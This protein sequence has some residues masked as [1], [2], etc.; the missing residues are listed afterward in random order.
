M[1]EIS[2]EYKVKH[3]LACE[4]KFRY[5]FENSKEYSFAYH[6]YI[7]LSDASIFNDPVA[8]SK[9]ATGFYNLYDLFAD[10]IIY[11]MVKQNIN[12]LKRKDRNAYVNN[13]HINLYKNFY[14]SIF[15][16]FNALKIENTNTNIL[17]QDI[18]AFKSD[19]IT[20]IIFVPEIYTEDKK[21]TYS[22]Y[23]LQGHR[24]NYVYI[25]NDMLMKKY[26]SSTLNIYDNLYAK[27]YNTGKTNIIKNCTGLKPEIILNMYKDE[28]I[29]KDSF[30][31]NI[32]DI[33]FGRTYDN[34]L[35][36]Y[37]NPICS[38]PINILNANIN[39]L[40][41]PKDR[42][43]LNII[44]T[45]NLY[46][47]D[48]ILNII[49]QIHAKRNCYGFNIYKQISGNKIEYIDNPFHVYINEQIYAHVNRYKYLYTEHILSGTKDTKYTYRP[50]DV[51]TCKY[52]KTSSMLYYDI[53][54][55][56]DSKQSFISQK[57]NVIKNE[58]P[59]YEFDV[60][61]FSIIERKYSFT[62]NN[63]FSISNAKDTMNT[64]GI[65][66]IDSNRNIFKSHTKW[67]NI[68]EKYT[69]ISNP[70]T[71]VFKKEIDS[72][73]TGK[74]FIHKKEK[75]IFH[76]N[77]IFINI[78]SKPMSILNNLPFYKIPK[79]MC[80]DTNSFIYKKHKDIADKDYSVFINTIPDDIWIHQNI[81]IFNKQKPLDLIYGNEH[82]YKKQYNLDVHNDDLFIDRKDKD[83]FCLNNVYVYK[84]PKDFIISDISTFI[85]KVQYD[86][87]NIQQNT[88]AL[89]K[90]YD[91]G[92]YNKYVSYDKDKK[93]I[94]IYKQAHSIL[95]ERIS[96]DV[97]EINNLI[98][99][100]ISTEFIY[101]IPNEFDYVI[102]PM[103]KVKH[104]IY[105]DSI[106]NMVY[107]ISHSCG[108]YISQDLFGSII[109]KNVHIDT[110]IFCDKSNHKAFIEYK[111]NII[112][113]S[114]VYNLIHNDIFVT[115]EYMHGFIKDYFYS[116]R[117][118]DKEAWIK[119][120]ESINKSYHESLI[121]DDI[122]G[123]MSLKYCE[124][125]DSLFID[126]DNK[127]CYYDYGIFTNKENYE[128][129]ILQQ[130]D[131]ATN[132]QRDINLL[133]LSYVDRITKY[134]I[135][136]EQSIFSSKIIRDS[137]LYKEIESIYRLSYDLT[138]RPED[139]GNW[140][141]VYET[142]DPLEEQYGIDELLIPENDT[143]YEDFENIIFDKEKMK[144]R[145]PVKV[146]DNTTFIAKYPHK[147]PIPEY[148][149]IAINYDDSAVKYENYYGIEVSIMRTV[150]LKYYRIWQSKI[151][152]FGTMTMVQAV[153]KMLE[154]LYSWI[155]IYFPPSQIEQALRVFKLIRW[156]AESAIIQN[157]QYIVS[158]EYDT[159]ESKLT[160]GT[161]AIP[162]NL[163]PLTN[164]TM[165]IDSSLGVIKNNPIYI[166]TNNDV[167]VEFY[168]DNHKNTSITFSLSN[169]VGS[170]NIYIN[171]VL[172]DIISKSALNLTYQIP[173]T[174][175]TNIVKIEK[176]AS[177]NLNKYFYIGNIKVPELTFKDLS[178]EFDATVKMGN[179]PLNEIAKKM[180]QFA[181]MYDDFNEA[182]YN[183][184]RNNL[185][186]QETYNKMIEYWNLHHQNKT[187]G[188]R[189]TIKE[190]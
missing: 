101:K 182:Y 18:L 128:L 160:S 92:L 158:Y 10:K 120:V 53:S 24:N 114:K 56:N 63:V 84:I 135:F 76:L 137:E 8:I 19:P 95:K 108:G 143:R 121:H 111:N 162:N 66:G 144:P 117:K 184:R 59:L 159:L 124:I 181:N 99:D 186:I 116:I 49:S 86:L 131:F 142:P 65:W 46:I 89:R 166:G 67:I 60:D 106:D 119:D 152:E 112:T 79:D 187:K 173:Y 83:I 104:Q 34:C 36:I 170:V 82:I 139:F 33:I 9:V 171:D 50:Y 4:A 72:L 103:S 80:I 15:D 156:Y 61:T 40:C 30:Y 97:I 102:I 178:I 31:L 167:S 146:I 127:I 22:Y 69:K 140:A 17:S 68:K 23:T 145:N 74:V 35:N 16:V 185:G 115:K 38:K 123:N 133:D 151:F 71:F 122:F 96:I 155:M 75:E 118:E 91:L 57:Y 176:L 130:K 1:G 44:E 73:I 32:L 78:Y 148:K 42:I 12:S 141:W 81:H 41:K 179:K 77:N 98:K 153:K 88:F 43:K 177:N 147:H 154:Y 188:K 163:G 11:P 26:F 172:V 13:N 138:I 3:E 52:N 164:D 165:I 126:K 109:S 157:S 6:R 7:A 48:N 39:L 55:I 87:Y 174:G 93:S 62:S 125:S 90:Y 64:L 113:K 21:I 183:V 149:D 169:T 47:P 37:E 51:S 94:E 14:T 105:I 20:N 189:L 27:K 190:I 85:S 134:K 180:V 136:Y 29:I 54:G 132:K 161:C 110:G 58:K 45:F 25:N 2:F 129:A 28:S 70:L 175:D 107:K 150:F 100:R 5:W 168:I